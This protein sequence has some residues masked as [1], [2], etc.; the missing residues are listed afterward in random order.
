MLHISL[1]SGIGGFDLAAEWMGWTNIVSCEINDFGNKV[2][3]HYWPNAY[4]HRDVKT[5]TLET[6]N[7][8][9]GQ[10]WRTDD[11]ILTGGF[12]CQD[13]SIA[14]QNGKGQKGL[15]G[16][17][18]GLIF[19]MFR[20]IKELNPKY[21]VAENVSNILKINQGSD[22][23]T[24]L[25]ELSAMGYNAE[26]RVCRASEIGAP[27]H[28]ARLYLVA[29][30]SS[31]RL[32]QTESFFSFLH[33]KTSPFTWKPFGAAIQISRGNSWKTEPPILCMD[34]GLPSKMVRDSLKGYGNSIVPQIAYN[35]FKAIEATRK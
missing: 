22:F 25:T 14:M 21:I 28:R 18:T 32:Q 34:D 17:R 8:Q 35:I 4:H 15:Q 9:L 7:E 10:N 33:E 31:F 23:T 20:I 26:W 1:F 24:I 12:P 16:E 13:A 27:H 19:E 29:Y 5:L 2:L 11:V 30:T 3:E 6:I